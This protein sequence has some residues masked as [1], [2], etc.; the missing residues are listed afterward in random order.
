MKKISVIVFLACICFFNNSGLATAE[1]K[2]FLHLEGIEGE[3]KNSDYPNWIVIFSWEW[4]MSQTGT[5]HVGGGGGSVK[6]MV[7]P[8][9]VTKYIDKASP[10]LIIKLMNGQH[11][12]EAVLAFQEQGENPYEVLR[13]TMSSV[14]IANISS[15]ESGGQVAESL[16]L[17][18]SKVCYAYTPQK[19]DGS[20]DATIERCWNIEKNIEE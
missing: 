15:G 14:S 3:S 5:M 8:V 6:G 7:R 2:T 11:I 19:A 9:I 18:F 1:T 10:E 4:Q 16:A 20:P 13:I 12:P 17:V